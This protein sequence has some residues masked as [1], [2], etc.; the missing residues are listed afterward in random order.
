MLCLPKIMQENID[1]QNY[2]PPDP[3]GFG[4]LQ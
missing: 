1:F 3:E 2:L 4:I